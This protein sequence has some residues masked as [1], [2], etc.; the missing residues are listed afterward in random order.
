[1]RVD[2]ALVWVT[3]NVQTW[4]DSNPVIYTRS[5]A[6]RGDPALRNLDRGFSIP[7]WISETEVTRLMYI[8]LSFH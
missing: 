7:Q 3:H 2:T 8:L 5:G 6:E 1:M 4:C